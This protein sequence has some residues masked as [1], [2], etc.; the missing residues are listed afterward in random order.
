MS[1]LDDLIIPKMII[2]PDFETQEKM[3]QRKLKRITREKKEEK[4]REKI[5]KQ[6]MQDKNV[7]QRVKKLIKLP[8]EHVPELGAHA[9]PMKDHKDTLIFTRITGH[10]NAVDNDVWFDTSECWIC[11]QHSKLTV[12]VRVSDRRMDKEF[13]QI[14]MLTAMMTKRHQLRTEHLK[15][16]EKGLFETLLEEK[17]HQSIKSDESMS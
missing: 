14:I 7:I 10:P 13:T 2:D 11:A 16:A 4:E 1:D 17:S 6:Q 3:L 15:E 5:I 9:N 12:D 8:P